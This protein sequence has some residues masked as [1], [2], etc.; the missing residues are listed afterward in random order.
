[1][2]AWLLITFAMG[3][4]ASFAIWSRRGTKARGL[5]V[6]AFLVCSPLAGGAL[7]TSLGWPIPY[8]PGVTISDGEHDVLGFKLVEGVAIYVLFDGETPRY[9]RM[10]W[11][12]QSAQ[13]L[14]AAAEGEDGIKAKV[15]P[16]DYTLDERPPLFWPRPQP[17]LPEKQVPPLPAIVGE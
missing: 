7:A 11:S 12:Q 16:F 10:P 4:V 6:A 8:V 2:I 13:Q 17:K 5:A 14:Q 15:P 1:M 3:A 9:Y